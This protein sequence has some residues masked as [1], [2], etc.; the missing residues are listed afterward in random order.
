MTIKY[1]WSTSLVKQC[2]FF[3]IVVIW[4]GLIELSGEPQ[5][6]LAQLIGQRLKK[7]REKEE[8]KK[9]S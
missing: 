4:Q 5:S 1:D 7:K 8:K 3:F 9:Q 2:C 6:S